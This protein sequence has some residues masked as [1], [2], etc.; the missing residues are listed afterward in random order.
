[1]NFN[2]KMMESRFGQ[3]TRQRMLPW[4]TVP[5]VGGQP[6]SQ[7]LARVGYL[8]RIH[9]HFTGV[10]TVTLGG[11]TAALDVL[12]PWN[13][14]NRIRLIANSGQDVFSTTGYG[15]YLV[16]ITRGPR[17]FAPQD[18]GFYNPAYNVRTYA[19]A[20][21]AGANNWEW[22]LTLPVALNEESEFGLILL[23]NDLSQM[24]L[25][26][27][28]NALVTSLT[29]T[30]APVLVTGAATATLTGNVVP[31]V[32]S[33][34]VPADIKSQPDISVVHQTL[35]V[36]QPVATVGDNVVNL[37]RTDTYIDLIHFLQLNNAPNT[38]DIDR[39]R[40]QF[41]V[42][43]TPYDFANRVGLQIQ[44][45]RYGMDLPTGVV[46]YPLFDQGFAGFG[47]E[48]DVVNARATSEFQS[49]VTI[50]STATLGSNARLSTI[51]RKLVA[52]E[53]PPTQLA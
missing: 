13:T 38:L 27:E 35:E 10:L 46:T 6:S 21:A 53:A 33:F 30:V 9:W 51:I 2:L 19:A 20:T 40:L 22:G 3:N 25:T 32:E 18:S 11:G 8:A 4:N 31:E 14:A 26:F 50:A 44:R 15:A 39:W 52:M 12:G 45:R 47:D 37:F 7:P 43:D 17:G 24:Q 42:S 49:I 23:Q 16:E 1:M 48:R 41:N 29:P 5:Y 28:W 34:T 36:T